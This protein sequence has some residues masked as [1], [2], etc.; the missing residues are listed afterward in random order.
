MAFNARV[1][2]GTELTQ[3]ELDNNFLSHYPQGAIYMNANRADSPSNYIGYGVW[4]KFA[5]GRALIGALDST[6]HSNLNGSNASPVGELSVTLTTSTMPDHIHGHDGKS[7]NRQQRRDGNQA[8]RSNAGSTTLE[9]KPEGKDHPH[10]NDQPYIVV[11]M[12][13]RIT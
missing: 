2:K 9:Y 1:D 11:Y 3:T 5:E 4:K 7:G 8:P 12:W 13:E 6:S 10:R